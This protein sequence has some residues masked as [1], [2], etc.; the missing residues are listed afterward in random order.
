[1]GIGAPGR[2]NNG[3]EKRKGKEERRAGGGRTNGDDR[4]QIGTQNEGGEKA[5]E[6]IQ[7]TGGAR[8]GTHG[9][10]NDGDSGEHRAGED[11]TDEESEE[12]GV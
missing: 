2:T 11:D 12:A 1:M 7:S 4:N 6:Q 8:Y 5:R 10:V 3:P 9:R